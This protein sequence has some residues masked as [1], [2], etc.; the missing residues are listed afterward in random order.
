MAD[1]AKGKQLLDAAGL[2]GFQLPVVIT[3]QG[4]TLVEPTNAELAAMLG[5]STSP[6]LEMYDLAVIGGGPAGLAAAVYGASEGLKTVLIEETTTG[7]QAGRSSRIENYLGFPTGVSG[8]ELDHVGAPTGRAVRRGGHHHPQGGPTGC[9]RR[10]RARPH[11]RVRGRQHRRR[12]GC[13]P[14]DRRRLPPAAGLRVLGRPGRHRVQ[15]RRSRRL[16]RRLG[17]R[18]LGMQRR[19][20]VHR[21]RRQLGRAGRDVHVAVRRTR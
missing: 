10:L 19:G 3:E 15:L 12:P 2:D 14:R 18:R 11:H 17:V 13:H 5:L 6:S 7:G 21:G 9:Q 20:R 1:E 16:L 8:A 4:E